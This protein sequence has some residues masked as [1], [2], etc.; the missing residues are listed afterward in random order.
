MS[1]AYLCDRCGDVIPGEPETQVAADG[2]LPGQTDPGGFVKVS[3]SSVSP[4]GISGPSSISQ[5]SAS[6]EIQK[7]DLCE[8]CAQAFADWWDQADDEAGGE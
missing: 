1:E 5:P 2:K 6:F 4:P 8:D 3:T 7:G